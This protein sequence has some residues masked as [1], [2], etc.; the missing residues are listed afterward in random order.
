MEIVWE[1]EAL[2]DLDR[3]GW[4]L[5]SEV[6]LDEDVIATIVN[7]INN[8]PKKLLQFPRIGQ[9]AN[10]VDGEEVRRILVNG[11]KIYYKVEKDTIAILSVLH[12]KE[13]LTS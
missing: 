6:K 5:L 3:I 7:K 10:I 11:Y 12:D 1:K 8:A 13:D 9:L 2:Q 4:F